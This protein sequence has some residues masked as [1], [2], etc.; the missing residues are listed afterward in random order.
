[1]CIIYN[2]TS[3]LFVRHHALPASSNLCTASWISRLSNSEIPRQK[4]GRTTPTSGLIA[5]SHRSA[6]QKM[7]LYKLRRN[8]EVL[9]ASQTKRGGFAGILN[10]QVNELFRTQLLQ[11][12]WLFESVY[13]SGQRWIVNWNGVVKKLQDILK[14]FVVHSSLLNTGKDLPVIYHASSNCSNAEEYSRDQ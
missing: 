4:D 7:K 14:G 2:L 5:L 12:F 9:Q 10:T 1:M 13:S 3:K 8:E 6:A 11:K